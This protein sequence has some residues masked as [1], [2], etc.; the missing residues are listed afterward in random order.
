MHSQHQTEHSL[1]HAVRERVSCDAMHVSEGIEC[2]LHRTRG[3]GADPHCV[4]GDS[5]TIHR[6]KISHMTPW[7]GLCLLLLA[8]VCSG[9]AIGP[10]TQP[11]TQPMGE[12]VAER[13]AAMLDRAVAEADAASGKEA[14]RDRV[15]KSQRVRD[16][17]GLLAK[18]RP[19]D[20]AGDK[21]LVDE[22][23]ERA[24]RAWRRELYYHAAV[25]YAEMGD[26]ER[27]MACVD[28]LAAMPDDDPWAWG[29]SGAA[30]AAVLAGAG[31][32]ASVRAM[33]D[34]GDSAQ[35]LPLLVAAG[36]ALAR[37]EGT[38]EAARETLQHIAERYWEPGDREKQFEHTHLQNWAISGMIGIT[39][40]LRDWPRAEALVSAITD[41][42]S[43]RRHLAW[44]ALAAAGDDP[45]LAA[46]IV[47][48]IRHERDLEPYAATLAIVQARL[49]EFD[50]ARKLRLI[51]EGRGEPPP[52]YQ[53]PAGLSASFAAA[54]VLYAEAHDADPARHRASLRTARGLAVREAV[55]LTDP[56]A[57]AKVDLAHDP[58]ADALRAAATLR[59]VADVSARAGD[60]GPLDAWVPD[61][62]LLRG[63]AALGVAEGILWRHREAAA[64][65]PA[66]SDAEADPDRVR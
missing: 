59:H 57:D 17:R 23:V 29:H 65:R 25:M 24:L 26:E 37:H 12:A 2:A 66:D 47:Q 11:A 6:M 55:L 32:V 34:L 43:R 61:D 40:A 41:H 38:R 36:E 31:D 54:A 21:A 8:A 50:D 16:L 33:I 63:S 5:G 4:A 52:P 53:T 20:P 13:A 49:G 35:Q 7:V 10:E 30:R 28:R 60:D 15:W 18:R 46:N 14:V 58:L 44:L 62:P 42:T 64:A 3:L 27:A 22:V 51:H 9:Q 39:H 1:Y 45:E 56:P 48:R 19:N